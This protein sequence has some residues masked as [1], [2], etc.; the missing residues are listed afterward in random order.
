MPFNTQAVE[1]ITCYR[2]YNMGILIYGGHLPWS[3]LQNILNALTIWRHSHS[4]EKSSI[5]FSNL[6]NMSY[7]S[8]LMRYHGHH[9]FDAIRCHLK[10]QYKGD[11]PHILF[12][13]FARAYMQMNKPLMCQ[14]Q[15]WHN[16]LVVGFCCDVW[17]MMAINKTCSGNKYKA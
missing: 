3:D 17:S 7:N 4:K 10:T 12:Y 14:M 13:F 8:C 1:I 5:S 6:A 11:Q 15:R 16:L 2:T 9:G